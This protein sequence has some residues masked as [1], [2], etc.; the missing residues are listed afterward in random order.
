MLKAK[1]NRKIM[2]I[3]TS[4]IMAV[5]ILPTTAFAAEPESKMVSTEPVM[6]DSGIM[7]LATFPLGDHYVGYC[8][9]DDKHL[10]GRHVFNGKWLQIKP[11]WKALDSS[12]SEIDMY[13]EV[14][15]VTCGT[16]PFKYRFSP[17]DDVDGKDGAGYWY[18]ESGWTQIHSGHTYQIYYEA[19][20]APGYNG[21][22][23]NRKGTCTL[24]IELGN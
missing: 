16:T 10:G 21:T 23:H 15:D 5:T 12:T 22:G 18:A 17:K 19:F 1:I 24:W 2:T 9:V 11:A 6:I 14:R 20:T 7:P 13:I 4:I 3:I 8:T